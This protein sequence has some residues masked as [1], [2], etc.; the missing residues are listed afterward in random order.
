MPSVDTLR[1]EVDGRLRDIESR[2]GKTHLSIRWEPMA[3]IARIGACIENYTWET[4]MDVLERL[5]RFQL[6]H[7]DDFVIEFDIVPL[8]AVR[9]ENFA[10]A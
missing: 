1:F 8:D 6:D 5:V 9:D 10:E 2:V 4:R 7:A 3:R